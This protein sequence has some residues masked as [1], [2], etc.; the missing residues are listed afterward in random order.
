MY[1]GEICLY[2][3]QN[4]NVMYRPFVYGTSVSGDNF[5][6]RVVET[7]R[8]KKNFSAGI[9]TILISPRRLGKTSLVKKVISEFDNSDPVIVFMD[10]Y[11]CRSA[12]DFYLRYSQS[13]L[14]ALSSTTERLMENA[15]EFLGRLAPRIS[16]S[17]DMTSE[18]SLSIGISH[19]DIDPDEILNLPERIAEK[20]GLHIVVCI[21]EFQQIGEF[22]DSLTFQK[23]L[24]GIW[25]HQQRSSYCLFGSK[26]HMMEK[27]FHSKRMPFY[28]FGDTI[29]LGTIPEADWISYICSRFSTAGITISEEHAAEICRK[30]ECYSSYVQQLAW[31]V[32]V[33]ANSTVT[34]ADVKNGMEFLVSQNEPL[35]VAKIE[36]LSSYQLNLLRAIC[37]GVNSGFTSESVLKKW[38]LGSKSNVARIRSSL[39][40]KEL[41]DKRDGKLYISDPVLRFWLTKY[42][43]KL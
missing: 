27:I 38:N 17:P 3:S 42:L 8:I 43:Q 35:Y 7:S 20:K 28:M 19:K 21:D 32:M 41:I 5:T 31:N 24:R 25:Q 33:N 10:I 26:K 36:N 40:E 4:Q 34:D 22:S 14:K 9:N 15:K 16:V 37:A 30:V 1:F 18:Y 23:R 29:Y 13:I 2:L 39:I 11:D 12:Q 6:D